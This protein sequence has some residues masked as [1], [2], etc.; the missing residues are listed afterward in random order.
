[1]TDD[2]DGRLRAV[3]RPV[4][5]GERFTRDVL[6]RIA[7]EPARA[8]SRAPALVLRWVPGAI[9]ASVLMGVLV[10]HDWQARRTQRGL[11]ARRQLIEALHVT[12]DKLDMAYRL[13]NEHDKDY[14]AAGVDAG[15]E[16]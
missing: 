10:A 16:S 9:A 8:R 11:E 13:V 15:P 3:L 2:L 1:M 4:D 6:E 5:P 7:N 12:S 14:G